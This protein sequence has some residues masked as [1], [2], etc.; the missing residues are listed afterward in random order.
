MNNVFNLNVNAIGGVT[1]Y[2][3]ILRGGRP[4]LLECPITIG[5]HQP[6]WWIVWDD[7]VLIGHSD[8]S[9]EVLSGIVSV[10]GLPS[11]GFK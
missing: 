1:E 7:S 8:N 4:E 2:L 9:T 6:R 5:L 3:E 11:N 10:Y